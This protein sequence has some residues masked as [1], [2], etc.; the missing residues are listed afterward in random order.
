MVT[1]CLETQN[2]F[3]FSAKVFFLPAVITLQQVLMEIYNIL[4]S[5]LFTHAV[6]VGPT[7]KIALAEVHVVSAIV[8]KD[9][10]MGIGV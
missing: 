1:V 5:P 2:N 9:F 6:L 4:A 3:F 7:I 8:S 10:S